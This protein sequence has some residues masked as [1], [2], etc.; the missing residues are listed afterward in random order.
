[1]GGMCG[2]TVIL[3][4]AD[5]PR[6]PFHASCLLAAGTGMLSLARLG[7]LS[8]HVSARHWR[9]LLALSACN[10]VS[11][12]VL[13]IYGITLL[14]SGRA[15]LLRYSMPLWSMILSVRLPAEQPTARPRPP[16]PP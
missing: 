5:V 15:A 11:W 14:P 1:A 8:L 9:P 10:I 6:H 12:N 13:V 16:A 7:G 4:L 3:L 2:P